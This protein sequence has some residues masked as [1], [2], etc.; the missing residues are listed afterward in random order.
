MLY[1]S[2]RGSE[3]VNVFAYP[4]GDLVRKLHFAAEPLLMCADNQGNVFIPEG[5]AIVEYAYG[6]KKPLRTLSVGHY[7]GLDSCSFDAATDG[8]AAASDLG[9]VAVFSLKRPF[10]PPVFYTTSYGALEFDDVTYDSGGNLFATAYYAGSNFI[11]LELS[12]GSAVMKRVKVPY[13]FGEWGGL[14]WDGSYVAIEVETSSYGLV[15]DRL[16]IRNYKA[17]VVGDVTLLGY[18]VGANQFWI[19]DGTIVSATN[20]TTN[21]AFWKYPAGGEPW[22]TI[23][24]AGLESD[25]IDGAVL[26]LAT[27]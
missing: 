12:K 16:R 3:S 17:T 8:L 5:S 25:G 26:T 24:V 27:K 9:Y 14:Q 22:R 20:G 13:N 21:L 18:E 7:G 2:N 23:K 4:H 10:S 1:V 15:I 6:G 11:F 19:S